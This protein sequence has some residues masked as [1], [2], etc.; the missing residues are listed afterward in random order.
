[1][2]WWEILLVA[3]IALFAVGNIIRSIIK[4]KKKKGSCSSCCVNCPYYKD[5]EIN[6]ET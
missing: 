1:M 5:C 3:A 2:S 6:K 4:K